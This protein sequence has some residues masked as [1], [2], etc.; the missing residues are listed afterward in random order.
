LVIFNN[1]EYNQ[2]YFLIVQ[3]EIIKKITI[4][5]N[6]LEYIPNW[7]I[8]RETEVIGWFMRVHHHNII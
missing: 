2:K 8:K 3:Q 1:F 4:L 6:K 7:S 5:H